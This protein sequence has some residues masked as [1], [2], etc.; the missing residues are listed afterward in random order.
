MVWCEGRPRRRTEILW[1]CFSQF[2]TEKLCRIATSHT[3]LCVLLLYHGIYKCARC[4]LCVV[5]CAATSLLS[6]IP[7]TSISRPKPSG[8]FYIRFCLRYFSIIFILHAAE[9]SNFFISYF[10]QTAYFVCIIYRQS[11]YDALE[12]SFIP[13]SHYF[14]FFARRWEGEESSTMSAWP[15]VLYCWTPSNHTT[16][17]FH[18]FS[19]SFRVDYK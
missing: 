5:Y 10:I 1:R 7:Q 14:L 12:Y 9:I 13:S 19:Y 17:E 11:D 6:G 18:S 8:S 16:S 15:L 3:I 4:S 2:L